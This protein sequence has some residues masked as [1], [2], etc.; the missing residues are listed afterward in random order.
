MKVK[1]LSVG[2]ISIFLLGSCS[3]T[4]TSVLSSAAYTT[5]EL[6]CMGV[7]RDGSQT[8]RVCLL[9]TVVKL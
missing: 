1:Y 6:V 7:E 8:L 2:I 5:P 3:K 9:F 4:T